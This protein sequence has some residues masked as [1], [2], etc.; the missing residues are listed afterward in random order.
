[1]RR[2]GR[3]SACQPQGT[4]KVNHDAGRCQPDDLRHGAVLERIAQR[5]KARGL[6]IIEHS[7]GSELIEIAAVNP[8]HI[9][10]GRMTVGY[11]G[12]V[13]WEYRGDIETRSGFQE[14]KNIIAGILTAGI[15]Q[16]CEK[17]ATDEAGD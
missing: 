12:F 11:D 16:I 3:K 2:A 1:M 8:D 15:R 14:V 5:L 10:W 9:D 6:Q 17:I 7:H 4:G 13:T